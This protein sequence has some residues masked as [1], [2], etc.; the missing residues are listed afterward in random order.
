MTDIRVAL[1]R[2]L[3][4]LA[5]VEGELLL[6]V[7]DPPSITTVMDALEER[8]PMLRGTIRDHGSEARRAYMRFFACGRD[9][10][11]EEP[12]EPLP[13]CVTTGA[14]VLAVVGAISGG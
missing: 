4:V 7:A 10:S 9:L 2:H 12:D 8:Y 13:D 6:G 1:P 11:H 14:D 3:R 5:R